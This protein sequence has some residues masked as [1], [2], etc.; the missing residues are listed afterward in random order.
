MKRIAALIF[1]K[2]FIK[3]IITGIINTLFGSGIMFLMYN[4]FHLDYWISSASNYIFGSVLSYFLNRFFTFGDKKY[5]KETIWKFVLNISLCY[6]AAYG[7][8]KPILEFALSG[9][10]VKLRENAAMLLGMLIFVGLNY[11]GQRFFVF[12]KGKSCNSEQTKESERA[13][14][15]SE[16]V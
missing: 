10:S 8:A 14:S 3:F 5:T 2:T 12:R 7:M 4:L 15:E 9:A 1:D 16:N 11:F 13:S 6:L